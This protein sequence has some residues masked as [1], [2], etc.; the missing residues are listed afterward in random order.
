MYNHIEEAQAIIEGLE[1]AGYRDLA[2][3]LSQDLCSSLGVEICMALRWHL[4][5]FR[6]TDQLTLP[7][8]RLRI[9]TLISY[10]DRVLS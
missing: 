1:E 4:K 10:L 7:E 6:D 5:Q 8:L 3:T 2:V 9:N